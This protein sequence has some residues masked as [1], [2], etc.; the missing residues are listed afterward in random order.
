MAWWEKRALPRW[1]GASSHS[2]IAPVE[3]GSPSTKESPPLDEMFSRDVLNSV[4]DMT[5]SLVN[6]AFCF[7]SLHN[8]LH[9]NRLSCHFRQRIDTCFTDS[10]YS[11]NEYIVP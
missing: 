10:G 5:T 11:L 1:G 7:Y 9:I 8:I 3:E 6:A 4:A 2:G